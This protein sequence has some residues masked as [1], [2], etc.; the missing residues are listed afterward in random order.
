[1]TTPPRPLRRDKEHAMIGGVCAGLA[2]YFGL[3]VTLTRIAYVLLT[4]FTAFAGTIVYV[5][6][7][8]LMPART[9]QPPEP[10]AFPQQH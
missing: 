4:I 8:I 2:E 6:L 3:D 1:M 10:S 9:A 7:W 5:I